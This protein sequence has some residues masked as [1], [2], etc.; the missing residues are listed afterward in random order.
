MSDKMKFLTVAIIITAGNCFCVTPM[1]A[2]CTLQQV[3]VLN[4]IGVI[5]VA[6]AYSIGLIFLSDH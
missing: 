1:V 6:I 3:N 2:K 4:C 5:L